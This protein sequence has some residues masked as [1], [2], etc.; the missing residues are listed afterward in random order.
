VVALRDQANWFERQPL[1]GKRILVTRTREQASDLVRLLER[2]GAYCIECPTIEVHWPEDREPLDQAINS[3]STFDWVIF[4]SAN[5][6]RFFFERL[7]GLNFDL[8]ALGNIHIAVV[9]AGTAKAISALHL[10]SDIM[11]DDFRAEGLIEAFSQIGVSGKRILIPRAEKAREILPKRL[12]E[13][14]AEVTL[15]P[16]YRT[17]APDLGPE[18]LEIL[19]Q[20][21]ID[22]LTFTSSSTVKNFFRLLPDDLRNRIIEQAKVACI[23]PITARTAEDFGLKV[24]VQPDEFTI[25]A[26]VSSIEACYP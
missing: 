20:E 7:F 6:V 16:A 9:G 4:S 24:T 10:S 5:A 2:R 8:R 12:S 15:V 18:V 3:L 23:G 13:L 1:L 17:L 14:G 22:V 11:P 21:T 25:P 26:L 19:G